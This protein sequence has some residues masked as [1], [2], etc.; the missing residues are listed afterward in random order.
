[1]MKHLGSQTQAVGSDR[2]FA[3]TVGGSAIA[4]FAL[5]LP[6]SA[7]LIPDRSL[8]SESSIVSPRS[9]Q[10]FLIEGGA[11]RGANLFHSFQDFNIGD[12]QQ[13]LFANPEGIATILTRVT[14][15]NPSNLFGTLGVN[16]TANLFLINPNGIVFGPNATLNVGGSFFAAT[17]SAIAF[18]EGQ[19]YSAIPS[20]TPPLLSI[21]VPIGLQYGENVR[22]IVLEQSTLRVSPGQTLALLGGEVLLRGANLT[23]P[24]GNIAIAALSSEPGTISLTENSISLPPNTNLRDVK[25]DNSTVS[26]MGAGGG[27]ITVYGENLNIRQSVLQT[28]IESGLGAADAV[29]GDIYINATEQIDLSDN[30][31]IVNILQGNALGTGGNIT[32]DTDTLILRDSIVVNETLS[33]GN[34]GNITINAEEKADFASTQPFVREPIPEAPPPQGERN[35]PPNSAGLFNTGVITISREAATG[36]AG[37]LSLTS[38]EIALNGRVRISSATSAA[39]HG[40]ELA[41]A[42]QSLSVTGGAVVSTLAIGSG[43]AGNIEIRADT[44]EVSD[45]GNDFNNPGG[46][47]ATVDR[48]ATRGNGGNI[49]IHTRR[50]TVRDS[51]IVAADLVSEGSG[52]S[53][54]I[55]A[56]EELTLIGQEPDKPASQLSTGVRDVGRGDGG[57]ILVET[58][59]LILRDGAKID[60]GTEGIGNS[61]SI[62]IRTRARIELSGVSSA[63]FPSRV[64]AQT[65]EGA[66]GEGGDIVVET[67][68]LL[69]RDGAQISAATLGESPGGSVSVRARESI[70]AIG[71]SPAREI[72]GDR[73][74]DLVR[75]ESGR[76]YPSG[77]FAS[78]PGSGDVNSVTVETGLFKVREGAQISVSS[79]N[80]GASGNLQIRGDRL[81]LE[82]GTL[83]AETVEGT[84]GNIAIFSPDIELRRQSRITTNARGGATGG[85]ITL[86][87]DILT[88]LENSDISAN[89]VESFG[90]RVTINARGILGAE[91]REIPTPESDITASSRR[92]PSFSGVVEIN[93]PEVDPA[94]GL[95]VLSETLSDSATEIVAGCPADEENSFAIVGRGGLPEDPRGVLRGQVVVHDFRPVGNPG[96]LTPLPPF[97]TREGGIYPDLLQGEEIYPPPLPGEGGRGERS[98]TDK[99]PPNPL[100]IEARGWIV[101]DR[102][103]V[104]LVATLPGNWAGSRLTC[105]RLE[106]NG[107]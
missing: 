32:I 36:N 25:L 106:S 102:G 8:G 26:A 85:N 27:N 2:R 68:Q 73:S 45:R 107:F 62:T 33:Q 66:V 96:D 90:G 88:A 72:S 60:V 39:G 83:S 52:G 79:Q 93:T 43:D 58:P 12:I 4:L 28:G 59:R 34:A 81:Q 31:S 98:Q 67:G 16:G 84:Q 40:G 6:S 78:S 61:G 82:N 7:Q 65:N 105:D 94:A 49:T 37:R 103:Q 13:V 77:I 76:R 99:N 50:M 57:N 87:T 38:P 17:A 53:I 22:D 75:D 92:G 54:E 41:I 55:R 3:L 19:L 69:L 104:E 15:G 71:S 1:M 100:T 35:P 48:R 97:P 91:F 5:T 63:G 51:G 14:G 101:N 11:I 42:T 23:A 9:P 24:G 70:E 80:Q 44:I 86:N 21:N 74:L 46:I 47:L 20:N 56:S 64:L 30:S 10:E 18:P 29:A 95:V 89:A